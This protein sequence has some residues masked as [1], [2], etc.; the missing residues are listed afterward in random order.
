M[1]KDP[2]ELWPVIH[3]NNEG[4]AFTNINKEGKTINCIYMRKFDWLL[5][6]L[7]VLGHEIVHYTE[8]MLK[9]KGTGTFDGETFAYAFEHTYYKALQELG[10]KYG[11][12][13]K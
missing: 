4:L 13:S 11:N 9:D 7:A 6:D 3:K 10:K 5:K 1:T 12:R 2:E 8:F